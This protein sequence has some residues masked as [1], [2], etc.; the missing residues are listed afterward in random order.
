[1]ERMTARWLRVLHSYPLYRIGVWKAYHFSK[2]L[3]FSANFVFCVVLYQKLR[4]KQSLSVRISFK[5]VIV[6]SR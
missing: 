1:M 4:Q 5:R 2:F 6:P 3:R